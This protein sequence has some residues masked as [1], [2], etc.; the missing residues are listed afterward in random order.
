MITDIDYAAVLKRALEG[1]GEFADIFIERS[2][3][4]SILCEDNRIEKVSSGLDCGA[5]LRVVSGGHAAYAYTNELT[6]PAMLELADAVRQASSGGMILPGRTIDLTCRH[7]RVDFHI[8]KAPET[9]S[10]ARKADLVLR[11]N[12]TAGA[13]DPRIRQATVMYRE[14]RQQ[15]LIANSDGVPGG[16]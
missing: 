16:G 3:P 6:M 7:P 12:R 4:F 14:N 15:V 11:A 10:T 1:G 13:V 5:G 9:V 8:E 2:S